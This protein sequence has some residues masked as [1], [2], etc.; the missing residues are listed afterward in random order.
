MHTTQNINSKEDD[1][2]DGFIE[3]TP[4]FHGPKSGSS[5]SGSGSEVEEDY[6]EILEIGHSSSS[7]VSSTHS[8]KGN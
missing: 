8:S 1:A 3:I 4:I 5:N 6:C 2:I 7:S